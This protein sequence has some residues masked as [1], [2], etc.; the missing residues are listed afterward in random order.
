MHKLEVEVAGTITVDTTS[1][2]DVSGKG[3]LPGYDGENLHPRLG[4]VLPR[5]RKHY[6][7]AVS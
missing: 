6:Q 1:R 5:L 7:R 3:Y 4:R 2:I